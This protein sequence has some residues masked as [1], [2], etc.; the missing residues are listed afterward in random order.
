MLAIEAKFP[1]VALSSKIDKVEANCLQEFSKIW[2]ELNLHYNQI[3]N[4]TLSGK[5]GMAQR[6]GP[7]PK[8]L[9]PAISSPVKRFIYVGKDVVSLV[10]VGKFIESLYCSCLQTDGRMS[11]SLEC[12]IFELTNVPRVAGCLQVVISSHNVSMFDSLWHKEMALSRRLNWS[13][14][15]NNYTRCKGAINA[16]RVTDPPVAG[17][18]VPDNSPQPESGQS[19]AGQASTQEA[20]SHQGSIQP[21][22]P[23]TSISVTR[24][25]LRP[26]ISTLVGSARVHTSTS[27]IS[28]TIP[29]ASIG[30]NFLTKLGYT[31]V[32][33][34]HTGSVFS[35]N[36][37]LQ[38]AKKMS[39][40][41]SGHISEEPCTFMP[42][43]AY[44]STPMPLTQQYFLGNPQLFPL[45]HPLFMP[46]MYQS[47][48]NPLPV[49]TSQ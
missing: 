10:V 45:Q 18:T 20:G 8:P 26:P 1:Y 15:L 13:L 9:Y 3:S 34:P 17:G 47:Y 31:P 36:P 22:I 35:T 33:N 49:Q 25:A 46:A 4:P 40:A 21:I 16:S 19:L 39:T 29:A 11:P 41:S 23:A 48:L 12:P 5:G 43:S 2:D 7:P 44:S 32:S 28:S 42:M 14:H 30:Q 38:G 24:G 37:D 27:A 6:Q